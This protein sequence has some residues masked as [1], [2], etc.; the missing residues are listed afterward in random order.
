LVPPVAIVRGRRRVPNSVFHGL[1]P[2]YPA[3]VTFIATVV[4]TILLAA[5]FT[6]SSAIKLF[7]VRQSLEFRDHLGVAPTSWRVIGLL[8]LAGVGGV[9]AG[10]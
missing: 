5:L 1:P 6:F 4:V 7:G 2:N 3:F 8:E 9:L 10:I